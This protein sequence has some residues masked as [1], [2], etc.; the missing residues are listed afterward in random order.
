[1]T[2]VIALLIG[3]CVGVL[4][5]AILAGGSY[6]RGARDEREKLWRSVRRH[7]S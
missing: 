6:E 5:M 7:D 1:V 2:E 3:A 4:V